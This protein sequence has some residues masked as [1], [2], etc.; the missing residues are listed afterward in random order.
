MDVMNVL[1]PEA[2]LAGLSLPF[3]PLSVSL[4]KL[5]VETCFSRR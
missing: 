3:S 2:E 1:P 5:C 4:T